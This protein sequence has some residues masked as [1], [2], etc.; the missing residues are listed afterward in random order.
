MIRS[1]ALSPEDYLTALMHEARTGSAEALGRLFEACRGYLLTV[2]H[3]Q[4]VG[5]LRAKIDAADVVQETFI[6]ATRDFPFFRGE[7]G[8]QLLGWLR[9]I[10]RNN[11]TDVARHFTASCRCL[12]QEVSLRDRLDAPHPDA[13]FVEKRTICEQLIAQELRR[14]LDDALQRLPAPYR[15]VLQLHYEEQLCFSKIGNRLQRSPEAARK[16]ATRAL[17]RLRQEMRVYADA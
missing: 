3:E 11:L 17:D 9:S 12:S 5:R 14:A 7:T 13:L 2:A 8:Q 15:Q 1:V 6:D 10:L 16:M 4:L